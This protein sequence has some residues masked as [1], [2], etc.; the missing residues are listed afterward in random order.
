MNVKELEES[1]TVMELLKLLKVLNRVK[2]HVL[3]VKAKGEH[4]SS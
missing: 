1:L 4:D 2:N 3:N